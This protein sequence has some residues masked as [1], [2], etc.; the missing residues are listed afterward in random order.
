M[1]DESFAS[2]TAVIAYVRRRVTPSVLWSAI[3]ALVTALVVAV[4][5]LVTMQ[6]DVRQLKDTVAESK[7]SVFDMQQKLDL[8]Q[9]IKTQLAVM[10]GKVDTI[11]DEVE[12]QR[13]WR[14]RIEG[15]AESPPH[16]RR[17]R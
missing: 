17:R 6:S 5:W 16:A 4:T 10:G 3:G 11:A 14:D 13:E 9:D 7:K 1:T 8:L 12:R 2:T 15:I